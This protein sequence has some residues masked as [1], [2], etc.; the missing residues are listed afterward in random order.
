MKKYFLQG[1]SNIFQ[2]SFYFH[3]AFRVCENKRKKP[4]KATVEWV[5]IYIK[6]HLLNHVALF[7]KDCSF[8]LIHN[9]TFFFPIFHA[10]YFKLHFIPS[11]IF[12]IEVD[13][14]GST[15]IKC[16]LSRT[17]ILNQNQYS[18]NTADKFYNVIFSLLI[19]LT[20]LSLLLI[21]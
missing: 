19:K 15:S 21:S 20:I 13:L 5:C 18:G 10:L 14:K 8:Y 11:A 4:L 7:C 6:S 2:N 3:Y 9:Q 12:F 17:E 16:H 1:K